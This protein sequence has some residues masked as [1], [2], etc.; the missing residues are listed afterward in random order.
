M[1]GVLNPEEVRKMKKELIKPFVWGMVIG[2]LVFVIVGFSAGWVV[3]SGSAQA[4]AEQMAA[5]AVIEQ[6]APIAVAQFLL[7]PDRKERLQELKELDSW[8]RDKFVLQSG[9]ATMPGSKEPSRQIDDEVV[10]RLME[11]DPSNI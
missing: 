11:L 5:K 9:W 8:K 2:A 10:R 1:S 4:K 7:D 3:T 6:L